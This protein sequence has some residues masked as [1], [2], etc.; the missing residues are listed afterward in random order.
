[1]EYHKD[2]FWVLFSSSYLS[3][4]CHF[5]LQLRG[6]V[7]STPLPPPP[8][9]PYSLYHGGGMT[10]RVRPRVQCAFSSQYIALRLL[11]FACVLTSDFELLSRSW[12]GRASLIWSQGYI[13]PRVKVNENKQTEALCSLSLSSYVLVISFLLFFVFILLIGFCFGIVLKWFIRFLYSLLAL[14]EQ[15][16]YSTCRPRASTIDRNY[17]KALRHN[18]SEVDEPITRSEQ[19]P[20]ARAPAFSRAS[21][22]LERFLARILNIF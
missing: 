21:L 4:I 1:M 16:I 3:R 10:M 8:P 13:T 19:L 6:E 17:W 12:Q 20:F 5:I 11:W 22:F 18:N 7:P 14:S 9:L 2:L 15:L